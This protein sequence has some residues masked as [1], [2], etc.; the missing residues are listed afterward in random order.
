MNRIATLAVGALLGLAA[1]APARAQSTLPISVEA[2]FGLGFPTGDFSNSLNLGYG[3]G[4]NAIFNLTPLVGVYG[5][6]SFIS[7]DLDRDLLGGEPGSYDVQGFDGGL[8]L[9]LPAAGFSP[10]LRGGV[11]YYKGELSDL[12][13]GGENTLGFQGG[14]GLESELGSRVTITPELSYVTIPSDRGTDIRF[15]RADFGL[16]FRL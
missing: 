10:Y 6:Y 5:G 12:R 16:R 15:I 14:V 7:F 11:A 9:S 1:A 8:R 4:A 3:L 2:R 13:G